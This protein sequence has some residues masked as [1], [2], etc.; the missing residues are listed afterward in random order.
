MTQKRTLLTIESL[1]GRDW[2]P[3]IGIEPNQRTRESQD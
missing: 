3:P 2:P 1:G